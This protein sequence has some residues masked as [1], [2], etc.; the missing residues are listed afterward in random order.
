M[1]YA[2]VGN[3]DGPLRLVKSLEES[4]QPLPA[5]I[6]LQRPPTGELLLAYNNLDIPFFYGFHEKKLMEYL[7]D[8]V[9]HSLINCFCNFRFVSLL[10]F[11]DCYNIHPSPLP[12]YKGRHPM[13]WALIEGE[14]EF[15][16]TIHK[17]TSSIDEG[18]IFWQTMVKVFPND[19]VADL[20]DRLFRQLQNGFPRFIKELCYQEL[21][22]IDT[23]PRM[24]SY[25]PPRQPTDSR[26]TEWS[27]PEKIYRKIHALRLS[28]YPAYVQLQSGEII[29]VRNAYWGDSIEQSTAALKLKESKGRRILISFESGDTL[30]LDDLEKEIHE[31]QSIDWHE[32]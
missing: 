32:E 18:P 23:M 28:S 12:A 1:K 27:D 22:Q 4:E 15:G 3:N 9:I 13:H 16:I 20:R 29:A 11:Y 8:Y 17:M 7:D 6:G 10:S 31:Q 21:K 19:S 30:W 5:C 14:K 24:P 2:I 26:L 25:F